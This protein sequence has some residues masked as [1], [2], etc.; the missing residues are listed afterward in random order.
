MLL[1]KLHSLPRRSNFA[2]KGTSHPAAESHCSAQC[3][4]GLLWLQI[5]D[6][7]ADVLLDA[8]AIDRNMV[9]L[10]LSANQLTM[11]RCAL[12]LLAGHEPGKACESVFAQPLIWCPCC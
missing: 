11:K 6:A 4:L 8:L 9:L 5:S 2:C 1:V 12:S 7:G 3:D 10:D